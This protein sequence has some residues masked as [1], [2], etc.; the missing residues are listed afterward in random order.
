MQGT[1]RIVFITVVALWTRN[2]LHFLYNSLKFHGKTTSFQV[3]EIKDI[4]Q[5]SECV[6]YNSYLQLNLLLRS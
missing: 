1:T 3:Y 4:S 5:V 2:G 6:T